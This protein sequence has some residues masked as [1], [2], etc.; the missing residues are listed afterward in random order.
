MLIGTGYFNPSVL[1]GTIENEAD[2]K[3]TILLTPFVP[4]RAKLPVF[5]MFIAIVFGGAA[6]VGPFIYYLVSL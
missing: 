6:W 4:C 3:M 5:A 1:A 2:R